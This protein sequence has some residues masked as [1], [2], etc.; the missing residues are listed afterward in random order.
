MAFSSNGRKECDPTFQQPYNPADLNTSDV[1]EPRTESSG[2]LFRVDPVAGGNPVIVVQSAHAPDWEYAFQNARYLLAASPATPKPFD[3]RFSAGERLRFR[4]KANA[5]RKAC[6]NSKHPSGAAIDP[7]W[8]GKH[9]PVPTAQLDQWLARQG[10]QG[11]FEIVSLSAVTPGYVYFNKGH[12]E[13]GGQ[14]LRS[15]MYEGILSVTDSERIAE[16]LRS[17]IGR[18]KAFGFGLLSLKRVS[19]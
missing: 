10:G 15:V 12:G 9:I 11:G 5:V 2:F 18:G 3:P 1:H 14:R 13:D 19:P 17:G 4:L 16:A 8:I 6:K 7:K